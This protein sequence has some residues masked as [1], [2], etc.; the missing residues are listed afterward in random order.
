VLSAAEQALLQFARKV[1]SN[2]HQIHRA[3]VD[4]LVSAGFSE[5]QIAEAVHIAALFSTFNRV[6]NAFGLQSQ[7]LLALY[8]SASNVS[9]DHNASGAKVTP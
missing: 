3:D 4:L 7:E 5:L 8:D 6:A 9:P 1:N 2:S